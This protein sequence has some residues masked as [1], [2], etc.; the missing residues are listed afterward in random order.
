MSHRQ[1]TPSSAKWSIR[2][3]T[4]LRPP[5]PSPSESRKARTSRQYT[6]ASFHHW[7]L[8]W[9]RRI[10]A[11]YPAFAFGLAPRPWTSPCSACRH[12]V[13]FGLK[14]AFGASRPRVGPR[15]LDAQASSH[16][17]V[18]EHVRAAE[19]AVFGR[20][21]VVGDR[22]RGEQHAADLDVVLVDAEGPDE[23]MLVDHTDHCTRHV[24]GGSQA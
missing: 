11:V 2:R 10:G 23:R 24:G 7:S 14:S 15:S 1:V 4:P 21:E 3:I 12:G 9:S 17:K 8:T 5:T 18:G 13:R 22:K 16:R 20:D 6:T 19:G